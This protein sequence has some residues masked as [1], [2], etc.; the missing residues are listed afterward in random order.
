MKI[1]LLLLF[2][3]LIFILFP[4]CTA[5]SPEPEAEISERVTAVPTR[6]VAPTE[7]AVSV[8]SPIPTV[9][10]ASPTPT[11]APNEDVPPT[12]TPPMPGIPFEPNVNWQISAQYG[13]TMQTITVD[14]TIAY[15]G[16]GLHLL[17]IDISNPVQPTL[18][19]RSEQLSDIV[20]EIAVDGHW[21]YLAN[22]SGGITI[23]DASDPAAPQ[24]VNQINQVEGNLINA[25]HIAA[26]ED[27]LFVT[28]NDTAN[29]PSHFYVFDL[30]NGDAPALLLSEEISAN[31]Q[32]ILDNGRFFLMSPNEIQLR[33]SANPNTILATHAYATDYQYP[34]MLIVSDTGYFAPK[35]YD[36]MHRLDLSEEAAITPLTN[37]PAISSAREMALIG[38]TLLLNSL[39]GEFGYCSSMITAVNVTDLTV[40]QPDQPWSL[41]QCIMDM[42]S[43]GELLYA[44]GRR[45][46]TIYNLDG[47]QNNTPLA[48]FT[49][50][51]GFLDVQT[52]ATG[53]DGSIQLTSGESG[54]TKFLTFNPE[55][56]ETSDAVSI[57]AGYIDSVHPIGDVW[58]ASAW[59]DGLRIVDVT[60]SDSPT[61]AVN[62]TYETLPSTD[63]LA[64]AVWNNYLYM[65]VYAGEL[66]QIAIIDISDPFNPE[67][68][69]T[70]KA[71]NSQVMGLIAENG[72]LVVF[73]QE[74]DQTLE[75]FDL[76]DPS[77][78]AR[79]DELSLPSSFAKFV[80]IGNLLYATCVWGN[81]HQLL[82]IDISDPTNMQIQETFPLTPNIIKMEL[83]ADNT[84]NLL[85]QE[86]GLWI[87]DVSTPAQPVITSKIP[88][89]ST[90]VDL[91]FVD[92]KI[93]I[94]NGDMGMIVLS[95]T[96]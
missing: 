31:T 14:D 15:I 85:T 29:S 44:V 55:T 18:F 22:G 5:T 92:E 30:T 45:G 64:S 12:L 24:I 35:Y 91:T 41:S 47:L 34:T 94:A 68:V 87:M 36:E 13:G 53:T 3:V 71:K 61:L 40:L 72:R 73:S 54:Q 56:T 57:E 26:Y 83:G 65:P 86:D 16:A 96:P 49:H 48:T 67:W 93:F 10:M 95:I 50:P 27:Q 81:C 38:D 20:H 80:A 70:F 51:D 33:D 58:I 23:M 19:H 89:P 39:F 75:L 42:K 4:A 66:G 37:G 82:V 79:L 25:G 84:I 17:L 74:I 43:N 46:F 28:T 7:T 78:L 69:E 63:F 11:A 62:W 60:N 6:I 8:P 21:I 2:A 88:L 9:I 59:G 77:K 32:I 52:I 90:P 1:Y 76:T